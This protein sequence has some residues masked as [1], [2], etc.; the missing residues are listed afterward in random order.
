[1]L[2]FNDLLIAVKKAAIDAVNATKPASIL[3]G[4]VTSQSPLV[5]SVDQKLK[6]SSDQLVLT[7]RVADYGLV[8]G[9]KVILIQAQGGQTFIV[10]DRG[11]T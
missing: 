9:D 1:M 4:T 6:L 5:I 7:Q 10:L 2:D 3:Y 8:I 11:G